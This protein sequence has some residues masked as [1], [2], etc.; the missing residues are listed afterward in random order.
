MGVTVSTASEA[1]Y[2]VTFSPSTLDEE[3]CKSPPLLSEG[4]ES[5]FDSLEEAFKKP[6]VLGGME[7]PLKDLKEAFKKPPLLGGMEDLKDGLAQVSASSP[8]RSSAASIVSYTS[9]AT[10]FS[11]VPY[12]VRPGSVVWVE[13]QEPGMPGGRDPPEAAAAAARR[14]G[15][16]LV[17]SPGGCVPQPCGDSVLPEPPADVN[18]NLL[19]GRLEDLAG[20]ALRRVHQ[21]FAG[22]ISGTVQQGALPRAADSGASIPVV[23]NDNGYVR[24]HPP[25][26][27]N[28]PRPPSWEPPSLG[29]LQGSH[30]AAAHP[31]GG[32]TPSLPSAEARGQR[33]ESL[34][35]VAPPP[36]KVRQ[37]PSGCLC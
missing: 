25:C 32:N 2:G 14:T 34:A 24:S 22:G 4:A 27:G 18:L 13:E 1:G 30:R 11:C 36:H 19:L 6:P 28:G 21:D 33:L 29:T 10:Q 3:A 7:L 31:P 23:A 17:S 15:P 12:S 5:P 20:D 37:P 26:P 16:Q 8:S 35:A 9:R